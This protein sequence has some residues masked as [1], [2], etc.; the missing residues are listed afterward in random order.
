MIT[1][2]NA[3]PASIPH[4]CQTVCIEHR[5]DCVCISFVY[6][7]DRVVCKVDSLEQISGIVDELQDGYFWDYY[8]D[9][10]EPS[11]HKYARVEHAVV[12]A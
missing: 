3:V 4:Q 12:Y 11:F 7:H 6:D 10:L 1:V 5:D 9:I 8:P 2:L